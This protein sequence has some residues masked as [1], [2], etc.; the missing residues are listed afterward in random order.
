MF[1]GG[2]HD[3][4]VQAKGMG[5]CFFLSFDCAKNLFLQSAGT[6][7]TDAPVK[8]SS[9]G[10]LHEGQSRQ[11]PI[12]LRDGRARDKGCVSCPFLLP[13]SNSSPRSTNLVR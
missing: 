8:K 1:S 3:S 9:L 11:P 5:H 12:P 10:Q 6:G 7:L 4:S 2:V 13:D